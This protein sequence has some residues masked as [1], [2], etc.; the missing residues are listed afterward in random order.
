MAL[1]F[2][3]PRSG[4][5]SDGDPAAEQAPDE[6]VLDIRDD[7]EG[8]TGWVGI[9]EAASLAGVSTGT[10]RQ[11]YRAGLLATERRDGERGGFLVRASDAIELAAAGEGAEFEID[12]AYWATEAEEARAEVRRL[13]ADIAELQQQ[14]EAA[15]EPLREARA[16]AAAARGA[17]AAA[18]REVAVLR[19]QL[20]D[21]LQQHANLDATIEELRTQLQDAR[22]AATFGSVTSKDWTDELDAS[23]R[24]PSRPQDPLGEAPLHDSGLPRVAHGA[25]AGTVVD[26]DDDFLAMLARGSSPLVY[27]EA[28][29]DLLPEA[30][31]RRGRRR[32]RR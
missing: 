14:I 17:A 22:R 15:R 25:E 4:G 32:S 7:D 29:D 18:E 28:A 8:E 19:S 26:D 20:A 11:W 3:R 31:E 24:G 9:A 2:T 13:S 21:A 1:E 12:D 6:E 23:Y 10:V 30:E 27:G 5:R 16:E